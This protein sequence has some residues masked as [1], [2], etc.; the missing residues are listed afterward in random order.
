VLELARLSVLAGAAAPAVSLAQGSG[1][2]PGAI[3]RTL[4]RDYSPDELAGGETTSS[5]SRSQPE[6]LFETSQYVI[7]RDPWARTYDVSPDGRRFLMIREIT[8]VTEDGLQP[9][10]RVVRNWTEELKRLVPVD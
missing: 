1:F 10:I 9:H 8:P 5:F 3:V 6:P 7:L 4:L 2:P